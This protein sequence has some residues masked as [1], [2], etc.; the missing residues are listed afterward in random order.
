M[1]HVGIDLGASRSSI[2]RLSSGGNIIEQC[3]V[4]TSD[5]ERLFAKWPAGSRVLLETCSESRKVALMAR[6]R[7]EVR[8]V[9]TSMVRALGVGA[10]GIK[11]DKR[12][13]QNLAMASHRLGDQLP[14]VHIRS[15]EAAG[16]QDLVRGRASFVQMRTSAINFVR[17]QMRRELLP[18]VRATPETLTR[19]VR[20]AGCETTIAMTTH[21]EIIDRLNEQIAALD[22]Q[23]AALA[24]SE[25]PARLQ[26]IAGVGPIVAL[27][28]IATVD[29]P[30]RFESAAHLASYVGLSPGESTTGGRVRRTGLIAAGQQQ[31]RALLVQAAH[32]MLN[33]RRTREPMAA[34]AHELTL[35][36]GRKLATCALARRLAVVMWAMLRDG[37]PYKPTMTK[38]R[39]PRAPA[40]PAELIHALAQEATTMT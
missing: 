12:D 18:R 30:K 23:L 20:E 9:P 14:H 15:E 31:L 25:A 1:E 38:P 13:A 22:K 6:E 3:E 29:D 35:K 5:L 36:R 8:V 27:A 21:L 34:W 2:C 11:T 24:K 33:S 4:K 19:R 26:K 10:R 40:N 37:T 16:L 17:S 39:A 32:S 7:H 28:F